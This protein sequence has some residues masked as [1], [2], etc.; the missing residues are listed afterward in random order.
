M[1]VIG[2]KLYR[3]LSRKARSQ[4]H[5]SGVPEGE[6][7]ANLGPRIGGMKGGDPECGGVQD[8]ESMRELM[9][10]NTTLVT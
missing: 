9:G 6:L 8:S 1:E 3:N 7:R 2:K 4:V 5:E 10:D